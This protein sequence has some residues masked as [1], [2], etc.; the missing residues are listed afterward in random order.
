M[1]SERT[2]CA[3]KTMINSF[4]HQYS[5]QEIKGKSRHSM[6]T[7]RSIGTNL[8][9]QLIRER[10]KSMRGQKRNLQSKRAELGEMWLEGQH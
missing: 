6:C 5:Q 2:T 8:A 1:N 3:G 7:C 10:A 4:E 9:D